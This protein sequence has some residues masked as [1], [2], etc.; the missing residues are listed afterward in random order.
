M[1]DDELVKRL[2]RW[3]L[4]SLVSDYAKADVALDPFVP[5]RTNKSP[6]LRKIVASCKALSIDSTHHDQSPAREIR[7]L[8]RIPL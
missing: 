3:P 7:W 5:L 6:L 8:L 2:R 4:P 1:C